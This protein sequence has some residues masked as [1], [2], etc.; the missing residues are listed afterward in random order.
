MLK[1]YGTTYPPVSTYLSMQES[2]C[3]NLT[4]ISMF[5]YIQYTFI[6]GNVLSIYYKRQ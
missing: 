4:T 1:Y 2:L 3:N 6:Y 5:L